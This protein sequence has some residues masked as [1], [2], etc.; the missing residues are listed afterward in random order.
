M[1]S[2]LLPLAR[3]GCFLILLALLLPQVWGMDSALLA[4]PVEDVLVFLLCLILA[5]SEFQG[6]R[7]EGW[8]SPRP[9]M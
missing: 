3:Q 6:W 9:Q 4:A 5:R 2:L 8:L 7:K 1:K